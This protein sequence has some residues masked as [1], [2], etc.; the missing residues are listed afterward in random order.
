MDDHECL[1]V[2]LA[3]EG[4]VLHVYDKNTQRHLWQGDILGAENIK[5]IKTSKC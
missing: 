4:P 5:G 2:G 3:G 1:P